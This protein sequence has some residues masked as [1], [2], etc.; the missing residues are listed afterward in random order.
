MLTTLSTLDFER[1]KLSAYFYEENTG[2]KS[3][4]MESVHQEP[5]SKYILSKYQ[6]D[7]IVVVGTKQTINDSEDEK[8]E[9]VVSESEGRVR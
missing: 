4:A 7:Q 5:G 8:D 6:I 1:A 3:T 9:K 2:E